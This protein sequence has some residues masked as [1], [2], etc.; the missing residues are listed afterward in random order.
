M[1]RV[2]VELTMEFSVTIE[3]R[4]NGKKLLIHSVTKMIQYI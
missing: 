4:F 3:G 1:Y 2:T